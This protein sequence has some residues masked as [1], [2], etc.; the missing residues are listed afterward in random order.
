MHAPVLLSPTAGTTL[1]DLLTAHERLGGFSQNCKCTDA[2]GNLLLAT[3]VLEVGQIVFVSKAVDSESTCMELE[4]ADTVP[5]TH[6]DPSPTAVWTQPIQ[7][8]DLRKPSVYDIG[9]CSIEQLPNQPEWLSADPLLGLKGDQFMQLSAPQIANPQQ[10]WSIRHQFL[11]VEDRLSILANQGPLFADDEI[12]YHLFVLGQKF[13]DFQVRCSNDTVKQLVTIDPVITTAWIQNKGFSC[14]KWGHD[15]GFV[16]AKSLPVATVFLVNGHWIPVFMRP[17]GTTLNVSVW[18][19]DSNDHLKLNGILEQLGL[20]MGFITVIIQRERR[21]FFTS[22]LCGTLAIAYLHDALLQVQLPVNHEETLQ[23]LQLYR[24]HFIKSFSSCDI[25]KRP[26]IWGKGDRAPMPPAGSL[27]D[28]ADFPL[29]TMLTREQRLDLI[30]THGTAVADDEI[31]F[32]IQH[33][34]DRYY[35]IMNR[36]GQQI[37]TDYLCFEPLVFTCWESIGR[38]ISARWSE[39]HPEVRANGVQVLTAFHLDNHWFP[40]WWAP[41]DQCI[42]FHTLSHET[43]DAH[44]LQD[45]CACIGQQLGFPLFA[46]HVIPARLTQHDLCG[47][48]AMM[49]LAHVVHGAHLPD[50]MDELKTLH[51]NMRATFVADLYTRSEFPAPVL[52]GNGW[53]EGESRPLPEMP[54]R[55]PF[56]ALTCTDAEMRS[57]VDDCWVPE[58]GESGL[59]PLMPS[60]SRFVALKNH[61]EHD[62]HEDIVPD[63]S[64]SEYSGFNLKMPGVLDESHSNEVHQKD[65]YDAGVNNTTAEF[66]VSN[67]ID[68]HFVCHL[69]QWQAHVQVPCSVAEVHSNGPGCLRPPQTNAVDA[70]ELAFHV[71][72]IQQEAKGANPGM[73]CPMIQILPDFQE[74]APF[75]TQF[76]AGRHTTMIQIVLTSQHWIPIVCIKSATTCRVFVAED[77]RHEVASHVE[78]F[79]CCKVVGVFEPLQHNLCGAQVIDLVSHLLCSTPVADTI[80]ELECRHLQHRTA[81][82]VSG[83]AD[84]NSGIIGFGPQGALQK[85]L[86]AEL[87][88][89]GVPADL[90]ETRANEAIKSLGS[91]QIATALRHRQPWRQLKVLG[92][93]NKFKFV[94]PSEMAQF[95]DQDKNSKGGKGKGKHKTQMTLPTELDPG[96]LQVLEGVFRFQGKI[97]PQIHPKQIG[98]VSSGVILMSHA[99]AEPYLRVGKAVSTEPLAMLVLHKPDA[100]IRTALPHLALTVPCRCT[101]DNEPLLVDVTLVQIGQGIVAKHSVSELVELD[102]L[103]VVTLKYLVYRDELPCQ[104]EDFSKAPI[105]FLVNTFPLLRR[106]FSEGCKC[107]MWHNDTGLTIKEPIVDVWRRQYLRSGFRPSPSAKAD[108]FSVCLRVPAQLMVGLLAMSGSAGAYC[109]PRTAD[110]TEVLSD[111]TVIWTPKMPVQELLHLKQTNP[112]II[113]LARVGERKGLRVLSNQAAAIHQLVRPDTVY[114]PQGQRS[115]FLVGPFPFGIDR[116]AISKAMRQAGW[117]CRPLQPSIP[118]PGKGSMWIVQAVEEPSNNIIVTS[119]G[120]VVITRQKTDQNG[121][122]TVVAPVASAATLALCGTQKG[123][124]TTDVDPWIAKD[125]WGGYRPNHTGATDTTESMQ[126][127]EM[128]VQNAVLA[129]LPAAPMEDDVPERMNHL[130]SQVQ[131]LM[132]KQQGMEV[133]FQEFSNHHGQQLTAMQAQINS[134]SQQ[135][136]GHIENQNQSIQSM[137]AQQ[138]EQIRGLLSKRPRDDNE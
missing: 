111:Y 135:L 41:K 94:L 20:S 15:H 130:E 13:L 102:T 96:K 66:L 30:S 49:F 90:A 45:V 23:R 116:A 138:M 114:L 32:H 134:Q 25:T 83:C 82:L 137:F 87:A 11:K 65:R 113:G 125:P 5:M 64:C 63:E 1:N 123:Q 38:T 62:A 10:L 50:T 4:K 17:I 53:Q 70:A 95:V 99:D 129:K 98:P 110:G 131:Q 42:T 35:A 117:E 104:W 80:E 119:H 105:K 121:K 73:A 67:T 7:E 75:F 6:I 14:E 54:S 46:L 59:L 27:D 81:Y 107:D 122:S 48:Q 9:E 68:W 58:T 108:M 44:K 71:S 92:N 37:V 89:H 101:L 88:N 61:A 36:R 57:K 76:V 18:D 106:C 69:F 133:Q 86:A 136:H 60:G 43:V 91:E 51:T 29:P 16:M 124:P 97:I 8:H 22:D 28:A 74:F 72:R 21:M 31:R 34:I 77:S 39:R 128:R 26:W 118:C 52:W 78:C 79:P 93:N 33:I 55:C 85:Q 2:E 3:Q 112:A 115:M 132:A 47:A 12:R 103:E 24:E 126:Q 56:V 100:E 19:A 127:L 120:E 84:W 40:V 109:E